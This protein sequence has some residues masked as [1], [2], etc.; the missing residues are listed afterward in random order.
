MAYEI[1]QVLKYEEK[2][3]LGLRLRQMMCFLPV[4][5]IGVSMFKSGFSLSVK[6]IVTSFVGV[7]GG[8]CAFFRLEEILGK[9]I[10]FYTRKKE[11]GYLDEKMSEFIGV[12][13]IAGDTIIRE[14]G[15]RV[16]LVQVFP[17]N[18]MIRAEGEKEAIMKNY[19]KFL[20]SLDFPIQILVRTVELDLD[21]Y[22]DYLRSN[23][24]KQVEKRGNE[25]LERMFDD[26][27]K[28]VSAYAEENRIK[29]RVFY[30]II[31]GSAA[32]KGDDEL[33]IRVQLCM[34]GL[35]QCGLKTKRLTTNKSISMLAN[36]FEGYVEADEEYGFPVI[37]QKG[38]GVNEIA[39]G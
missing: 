29:N 11:I 35:A 24:K 15:G 28:H 10:S 38:V 7:I 16:A 23:V 13:D 26:Y 21:L 6:I 20:N 8:S 30:L 5:V 2:I 19:Q 18:F 27:C 32:K 9:F 39:E 34:D 36:F 25:R 33:E 4:I 1:P 37:T 3:I 12:K 17:I 31:P 14:N 22:L